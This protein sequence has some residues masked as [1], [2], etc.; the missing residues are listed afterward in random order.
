[1]MNIHAGRCKAVKH[2]D[3]T[4]QD[5]RLIN[6]SC[7]VSF[8][9]T[10]LSHRA[11]SLREGINGHQTATGASLS[12]L[13]LKRSILWYVAVALTLA[14]SAMTSDDRWPRYYTFFGFVGSLFTATPVIHLL[15]HRFDVEG[16][17]KAKRHA[18]I[19]YPLLASNF[20][21]FPLE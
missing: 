18:Y 2:R 10:S 7:I 3:Q 13:F 11:H 17:S 4:L 5:Y 14:T 9:T 19:Q 1:M 8:C 6:S 20:Y 15:V 16:D 21:H 12:D